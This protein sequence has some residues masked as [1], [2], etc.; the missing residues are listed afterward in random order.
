MNEKYECG[1]WVPLPPGKKMLLLNSGCGPSA[2]NHKFIPEQQFFIT[3][4]NSAQSFKQNEQ[5]RREHSGE[6]S[7]RS[8]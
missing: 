6:K 8:R 7:I 3:M 4:T 5:V 2:Q 1:Q